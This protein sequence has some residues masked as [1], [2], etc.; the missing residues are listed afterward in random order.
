MKGAS[1]DPHVVVMFQEAAPTETL[2][3]AG[4][5]NEVFGPFVS[6]EEAEA[7]V[8]SVIGYIK[9]RQWLITPLSDPVSTRN[10]VDPLVN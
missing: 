2:S 5:V 9:D 3:L 7:W 4:Q 1:M 10:A 8:D 6:G